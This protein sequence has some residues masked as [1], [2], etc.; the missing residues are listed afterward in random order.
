MPKIS[1]KNWTNW[2]HLI[3][4]SLLNND[5]FIPKNIQL[6]ISVSGGQDSMALLHLLNE[7]KDHYNWIIKVWHG[8]H[9]WHDKSSDYANELEHFCSLRK[10]MFYSDCANNE[11][12]N[13]EEKA[14]NWR[15]DKLLKI[16]KE[17][18]TKSSDIKTVYIATGH[19]G[20]DNTETFLLNLAR[21][22]N[23][24]GLRGIPKKRL[25]NEQFYVVRPILIFSRE[26]TFSI[27]KS[28]K[29]PIWEDPTNNDLTIKRNFIREKILIDLEKIYPGCSNR[30]NNFINKMSQVNDERSDLSKLA[31][32][33]CMNNNS[34]ERKKINSLGK[35]A[36]ATLLN[37]FLKTKCSKQ[38]S[39]KNIENIS[40]NIFQ[41]QNGQIDL[42]EDLKI[43]WNENYILL[44][45]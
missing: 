20:T 1:K 30:I 18:S 43:I 45:N 37:L 32:L 23:Y 15:Y 28:M 24:A 44:K 27:C 19:T 12:I 13:N 34:L 31:L 16:A 21:G 26:E 39:S 11:N 6:L 33:S 41:K 36:R 3:H 2:H 4:K 10:I 9:R 35:E 17:I 25:L 14:R 38:I 42:P 8:D 7:L 29:I 40:S 22:S 5:H